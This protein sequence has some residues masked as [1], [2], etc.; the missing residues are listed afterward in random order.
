MMLTVAWTSTVCIT[1]GVLPSLFSYATKKPNG[2]FRGGKVQHRLTPEI[3]HCI[4]EFWNR[5]KYV[6]HDELTFYFASSS[7]MLY[8]WWLQK[9]Y[10]V[11]D[12]QLCFQTGNTKITEVV[13]IFQRQSTIIFS[14]SLR[15]SMIICSYLT[16]NTNE[17]L[18]I[19]RTNYY[20]KWS[21]LYDKWPTG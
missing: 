15:V 4:I 13:L 11:H 9:F 19:L 1:V 16:W 18:A 14:A 10:K 12:L 5:F 3:K 17:W 6:F 7:S 2:R 8:R 20:S 21:G